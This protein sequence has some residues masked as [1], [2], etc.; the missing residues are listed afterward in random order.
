MTMTDTTAILTLAG[1]FL[2]AIGLLLVDKWRLIFHTGACIAFGVGLV[3][4]LV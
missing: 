1:L 2:L 4:L 3:L